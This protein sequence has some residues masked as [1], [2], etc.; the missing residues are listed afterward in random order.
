[1]TIEWPKE[2]KAALKP[3]ANITAGELLASLSDQSGDETSENEEE[4]FEDN[5]DRSWKR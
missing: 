1:M 3:K 2:I 4:I 5:E